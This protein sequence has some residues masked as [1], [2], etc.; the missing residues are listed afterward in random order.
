MLMAV[1]VCFSGLITKTLTS[2]L[3]FDP[4]SIKNCPDFAYAAMA[5]AVGTLR[6]QPSLFIVL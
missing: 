2:F 1:L 5:L 6:F 4:L 3:P